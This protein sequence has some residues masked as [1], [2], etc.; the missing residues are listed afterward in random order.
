[1]PSFYDMSIEN[2]PMNRLLYIYICRVYGLKINITDASPTLFLKEYSLCI[3]EIFYLFVTFSVDGNWT[4]WSPYSA[5]SKPCG[6]GIRTRTRY[7]TNP[8]P[9]NGGNECMGAGSDQTNCKLDDCPR[10][11]ITIIL[12]II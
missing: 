1:M 5:C 4:M 8:R 12:L 6:Q 11:Y 7:C 9:L 10:N 2:H 3:H